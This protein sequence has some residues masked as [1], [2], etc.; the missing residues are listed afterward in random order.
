MALE[1]LKTGPE[2][3]RYYNEQ[4]E[5]IGA[6]KVKRFA[7]IAAGIAR[8]R[9]IDERVNA[10]NSIA[11]EDVSAV[12]EEE[13]KMETITSD[14]NEVSVMASMSFE[15]HIVEKKSPPK[16][17]LWTRGP[18]FREG[19]NQAKLIAAL[20]S[21]A[22]TLEEASKKVYGTKKVK[23]TAI[24]NVWAGVRRSCEE[25]FLKMKIEKGTTGDGDTTFKLVKK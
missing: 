7:T 8:C 16:G 23:K 14:P 13:P 5:K 6:E 22:M 25:G 15:K 4:A 10:S 3:V 2:L 24:A 9:K 21:K 17:S 11:T 1:E 20:S 18:A 12:T 19:S